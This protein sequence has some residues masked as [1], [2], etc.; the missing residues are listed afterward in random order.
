MLT[1]TFADVRIRT[2]DL[3]GQSNKHFTLVNYDYLVI[4]TRK[5]RYYD[6]RFLI[7]ER[8]MFLTGV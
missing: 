6:F 1:L 5:L 3:C 8:K 7:Y 2:V 4:L